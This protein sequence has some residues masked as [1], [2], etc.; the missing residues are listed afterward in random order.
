MA[1][2]HEAVKK[3]DRSRAKPRNDASEQNNHARSSYLVF[4][5][6]ASEGGYVAVVPALPGCHSQG[7]TLEEAADNIKEAIEVYLESLISHGEPN[8]EETRVFGGI[9]TVSVP[10]RV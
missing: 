2:K 7:D 6:A 1:P 8:P 3:A 4:Y 9:V 10:M 5:E